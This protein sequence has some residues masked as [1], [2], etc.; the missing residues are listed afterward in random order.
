M[1]G[2]DLSKE[3]KLLIGSYATMEYSIE[4]AAIFNPSIIEDLDQSF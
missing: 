1:D 4:S 2:S 3:A